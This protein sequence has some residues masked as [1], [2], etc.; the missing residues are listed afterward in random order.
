METV[1]IET[2]QNVALQYE[3]ATIVDRGV[4]VVLD[5][6]V[7][8]GY[9][10]GLSMLLGQ[11]G[12]R[13]P[14]W[15]LISLFG[16]PWTF[17]HLVCELLMDGQSVGKRMRNIKVAR[18]DGGQPGL[19]HYL[20]RWLLR[21]VDSLFLVGGV[22]ILFNGKGQRIGD[23][24]AG[25]TVISLRRRNSLSDIMA[26]QH[27]QGHQVTF[28]GAE[29]IPDREAALIKEVLANT[30]SARA[31]AMEKLA[32]RYQPR[33]NANG[34]MPPEQFLRTLLADHLY[35]TSR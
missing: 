8:V 19:G 28:P 23:I 5:W 1:R 25:T 33:F 27:A 4:A 30:S 22:V 6:L 24:A 32:G 18:L 12:A 9:S 14:E 20:L 13:P 16:V 2:A 3:V 17:Y 35:L 11:T 21:M 29:M 26:A 15:L 7:L 10:F 31:A 34:Q